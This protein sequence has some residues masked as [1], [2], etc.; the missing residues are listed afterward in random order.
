MLLP[1]L[2]ATADG[3]TELYI[4][5]PD[6]DKLVLPLRLYRGLC[7]KTSF[8]GG[9][10]N[11]HRVIAL[12]Q[13]ASTL[14]SVKRGALPAFHA[15]NG[16]DITSKGKLSCW[17]TFMDAEEDNKT[18]LRNVGTTMHPSDEILALVKKA[19]MPGLSAWNR[20]LAS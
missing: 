20:Y 10:G 1:P 13:V 5:S 14:S 2:D 3:A 6:T 9:T 16:T 8:V 4:H 17:K 11:N 19:Y 15:F 7:V 18:A 12:G